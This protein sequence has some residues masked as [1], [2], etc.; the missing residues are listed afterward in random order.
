[1]TTRRDFLKTGSAAVATGVVFCSCG[2]LRSAHAQQ[3]DARRSRSGS[4]DKRVR[5]IDVHAH[6]HFREA[7]ALL[8]A[9]AAAAQLPPVN[10]AEEAFIEIDQR[11]A[12]MDAQAVDM[13]VL[14]INP[15]WY[16]RERDL[17][18]QIVKIQ[19]EKLA[20]LC[21]SK[22]DRFAGFRF[23][24][25]AGARSRRAG[26]RDRGEEA[27]P[28]GRRDRRCRRRRRILRSE[29]PSRWA[30]AEELG[31]PLFIHPQGI[32]ELNK[33]LSGNGWLGNTIGNP[34]ADDD[35]ALAPH[36]RGHLRPL[37]RAESD[38][39]PWRRLPALLRRSFG[40]CLPGRPQ[41]L[42]SECASSR[43]SRPNIS[44]RS[45]SIP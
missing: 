28:E 20:E 11:L 26:T 42:Q 19:N 35:R 45:I 18:G 33:R 23:A 17:A 1:M 15:F 29:I 6:C 5:T 12:A 43:K 30:K 3:P 37:S 10:G 16:N 41:R 4:P 25:P 24:D 34:L 40:P 2:L 22:P 38:R 44:S 21:A 9:D 27:G 7:G 8:G 31:V 32:P 14:S 36:L 39:G 13:E